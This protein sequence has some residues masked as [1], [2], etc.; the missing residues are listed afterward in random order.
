[1]YEGFGLPI[2]EAMACNVPVL[3]SNKASLPEVGGKAVIYFEPLNEENLKDKII[4]LLSDE[5]LRK[6]LIEQGKKQVKKFSWETS[7]QRHIEAFEQW[8]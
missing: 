4:Q 1:L 6:S 2:L 7:I 8:C 5:K 3:S